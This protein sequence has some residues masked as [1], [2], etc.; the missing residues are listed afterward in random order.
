MMEQVYQQ[1]YTNEYSIDDQQIKHSIF[2]LN[3]ELSSVCKKTITPDINTDPIVLNIKIE[4]NTANIIDAA[5]YP[6][7]LMMQVL[8]D[9]IKY[10]ADNKVEHVTITLS[11]LTG[12]QEQEHKFFVNYG[13]K[14]TENEGFLHGEFDIAMSKNINNH[15]STGTAGNSECSKDTKAYP[16]ENDQPVDKRSTV[17]G[18]DEF[19]RNVM[20]PKSASYTNKD[21]Y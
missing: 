4:G 13:F 11:P 14:F 20:N 8:D 12:M 6:E 21:F 1:V 17:S 19:F 7:K 16:N 15:I 5:T 18:F 2:R 10:L 3:D 9:N